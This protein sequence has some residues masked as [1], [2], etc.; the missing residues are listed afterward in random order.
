[1]QYVM[2]LISSYF[3]SCARSMCRGLQEVMFKDMMVMLVKKLHDWE[4]IVH[5][6]EASALRHLRYG[7]TLSMFP[8]VGKVS[9]PLRR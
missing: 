4:W 6:L 7:V 1:M 2:H 5:T 3:Q 8:T 9:N